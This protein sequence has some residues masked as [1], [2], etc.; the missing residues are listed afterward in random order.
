MGRDGTGVRPATKSSIEIAFTYKGINVRER[1]KLKPTATNI[2]KCIRH[3]ESILHA[4]DHNLFDY[5]ITFPGSKNIA[6]FEEV[7]IFT[8]GEWLDKWMARKEKH[9]KS[10][11]YLGYSKIVSN[12]LIPAFGKIPLNDLKKRHV[13][14]WCESLECTNKRIANIISPLRAALQDAYD[15]ELVGENILFNFRFKKV[16]PPKESD[17][18]PFTK[19]EREA[20]LSRLD[21]QGRNLIEFAFWSGLRTSELIALE[22]NDID[23][24]KGS[25]Y[26]SRAK[27]EAAKVAETTK[28][29]SGTREVKLLPP[30]LSAILDQKQ[31]TF[32][33]GKVIFHNPRTNKQWSGDQAIRKTLW[34]HAL[35]KAGVRY[36]RPY[37]T[38]HT[39]ASMMLSSGEPL[40]WVS[41]Q[42]GHSSV[43]QTAKIYA[44]WIP[45]SQPEAGNKAVEIFGKTA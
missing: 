29:Q 27:T 9:L 15:D 16:E 1:I 44:T 5:A 40:A 7:T 13:R 35:K 37:Q 36:R 6:K 42:L 25:V 11:T 28:T 10:S 38:R 39:Y 41:K 19:D 21:S 12:Q 2:N 17:I 33:Q 22:W 26:V 18:Q 43:I 34:Q 31:H 24:I 4:I 3:R 14:E 30:A 20:I 8:V 45:D 32:L 23:F